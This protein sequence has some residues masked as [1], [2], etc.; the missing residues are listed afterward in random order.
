M[1]IAII[2]KKSAELKIKSEA[3]CIIMLRFLNGSKIDIPQLVNTIG[4]SR[5]KKRE[6]LT[7]QSKFLQKIRQVGLIFEVGVLGE[8]F[9][10]QL[11]RQ[12][13]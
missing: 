1:T 9:S 4:Q 6:N 8:L 3:R 10:P 2:W 11:R 12:R 7:G 5:L 13:R